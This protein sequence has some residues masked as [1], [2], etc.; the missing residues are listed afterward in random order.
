MSSPYGSYSLLPIIHYL[1][2]KINKL[3]EYVAKLVKY[4]S[5]FFQN[6]PIGVKTGA[7]PRKA[8]VFPRVSAKTPPWFGVVA[9]S[10]PIPSLTQLV[11]F[12]KS[13]KKCKKVLYNFSEVKYNADIR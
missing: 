4:L 8:A 9:Q 2:K 10:A 3:L 12:N 5:G 1:N 13:Y 11:E 7:S 6:G